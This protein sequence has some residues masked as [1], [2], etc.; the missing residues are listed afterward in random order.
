MRGAACEAPRAREEGREGARDSKR[1]HLTACAST[2]RHV[3]H[4]WSRFPCITDDSASKGIIRQAVTGAG[5]EFKRLADEFTAT[6]TKHEGGVGHT[7]L[8][9]C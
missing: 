5:V 4:G 3:A 8:G 2:S 9:A 7:F 1:I 6:H